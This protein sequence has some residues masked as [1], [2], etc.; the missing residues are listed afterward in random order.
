VLACKKTIY[1]IVLKADQLQG[2]QFDSNSKASIV[3]FRITINSKVGQQ[4]A[5]PPNSSAYT[6][7]ET[8]MIA[9]LVI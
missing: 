5:V 9:M 7:I 4:C 2:A 8:I 1:R 6:M 3:G